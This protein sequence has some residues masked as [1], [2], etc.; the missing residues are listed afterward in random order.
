[1]MAKVWRTV[2]QIRSQLLP[3]PFLRKK[4]SKSNENL[5]FSEQLY[6]YRG[7]TRSS[8]PALSRSLWRLA[9]LASVLLFARNYFKEQ[10]HLEDELKIQDR[11]VDF[12]QANP[13]PEASTMT[14]PDMSDVTVGI[15]SFMSHGCLARAI[16]SIRT[17]YPNAWILVLDDAD[18]PLFD[19]EPEEDP[20][21]GLRQR[22]SPMTPWN[23]IGRSEL[24]GG[25]RIFQGP[26]DKNVPA[27][28]WSRNRIRWYRAKT[29]VVDL[30]NGA[31]R[32]RLVELTH[33][34]YHLQWNDD[35]V[36]TQHSDVAM[37][38]TFLETHEYDVVA[39][40]Y[41]TTDV[42]F[43]GKFDKDTEP[44]VLHQHGFQHR[45]V[46][47]PGVVKADL[48]DRVMLARTERLMYTPW[49]ERVHAGTGR[50]EHFLLLINLWI[51]GGKVAATNKFRVEHDPDCQSERYGRFRIRLSEQWFMHGSITITDLNKV[52]FADKVD[53]YLKVDRDAAE[54][55]VG[56]ARATTAI[57]TAEG[58]R[59]E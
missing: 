54:A 19:G 24:V 26:A 4:I 39:G 46:I 23:G 13:V 3:T 53:S 22:P 6:G 18:R 25:E 51:E 44:G 37:L 58:D 28:I 17:R 43:F 41:E 20:S 52:G 34:K 5:A 47:E 57:A 15:Y 1:M 9:I 7:R 2:L 49:S 32:N 45:G 59:T 29:G 16:M 14:G 40:C 36:L 27:H 31:G 10:T 35:W 30:G 12:V 33:T 21:V 56:G 48:I 8:G 42:G 55:E 50:G 11:I 38:R